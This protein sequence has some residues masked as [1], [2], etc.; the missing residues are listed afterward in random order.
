MEGYI[1]DGIAFSADEEG[2]LERAYACLPLSTHTMFCGS[3]PNKP[4]PRDPLLSKVKCVGEGRMEESKIYLGW[5]FD[6]RQFT[7]GLPSHKAKAYD[8][9]IRKMLKEKKVENAKALEKLIGRLNT[10]GMILPASRHFTSRLRHRHKLIEEGNK[11]T[12][13]KEEL[14]DLK[15]WRS[16]LRVVEEGISINLTV[17]QRTTTTI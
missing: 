7:I 14:E 8:D 5:E 6:L 15:L 1:D 12:L 17:F 4:I 10:V 9:C 11:N 2:L 3:D 13:S 16:I